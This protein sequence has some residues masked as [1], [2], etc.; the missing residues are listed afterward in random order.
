MIIDM[1]CKEGDAQTGFG[2]GKFD[3]WRWKGASLGAFLAAVVV[4]APLVA[5]APGA[6]AAEGVEEKADSSGI[7]IELNRLQEVGK[8]CRLSFVF[9]NKLPH[10]VAA[11]SI[12]TVLFN[13][14]GQVERLLALKSKPLTSGKIRVQQFE[15]SDTACD[16]IGR[17]LINDV[18]E[19]KAGELTA[20]QCLQQIKPSSRA[21]IP[22]V[23]VD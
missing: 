5:G 21:D 8:A 7:A 15:L 20:A 17:V 4:L 10:Q 3:N 19:C 1:R 9:T 22:F 13:G 16:G 23:S 18:T 6:A 14:E 2:R 11:L 12:E